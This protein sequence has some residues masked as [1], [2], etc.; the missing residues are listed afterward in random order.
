MQ[1]AEQVI[2]ELLDW[3]DETPPPNLTQIEDV[4]LAL[5]Q[6]LSEQMAQGVIEAQAGKQPAPGVCCPHCGQ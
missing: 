3:T 4:I 6:R 1:Q 2:D 5:R